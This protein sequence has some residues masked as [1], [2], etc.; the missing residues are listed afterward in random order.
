MANA[1]QKSQEIMGGTPV[2]SGTRVPV[3]TLLDYIEGG[4]TVDQFLNDFPTVNRGQVTQL[5][6]QIK[7]KLLELAA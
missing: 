3:R 2:F 6:E 5:I 4:D 7:A 1:V